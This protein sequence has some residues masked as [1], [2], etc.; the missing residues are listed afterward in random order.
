MCP[1]WRMSRPT[2][3]LSLPLS[4]A[5]AVRR[6]HLCFFVRLCAALVIA[7]VVCVLRQLVTVGPSKHSGLSLTFCL[8]MREFQSKYR[9][10]A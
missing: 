10:F 4:L 9:T 3:V 8:C 1:Y 2:V 6:V 5:Q 7:T